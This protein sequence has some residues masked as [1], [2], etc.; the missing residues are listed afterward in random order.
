MKKDNDGFKDVPNCGVSQA[1]LERGYSNGMAE[2]TDRKD[3]LGGFGFC[4][5]FP[6]EKRFGG[7]L[8]RGLIWER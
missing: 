1:D 6:G 5:D 2:E 8:G 4:S 7:F 3:D